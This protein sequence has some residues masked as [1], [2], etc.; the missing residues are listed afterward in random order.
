MIHLDCGKDIRTPSFLIVL[1]CFN[2]TAVYVL[3]FA[4]FAIF[5]KE[6]IRPAR[7]SANARAARAQG[8]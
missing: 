8:K 5:F 1:C 6:R 2:N 4:T 3:E 7:S